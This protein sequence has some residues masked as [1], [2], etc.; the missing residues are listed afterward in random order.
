[1]NNTELAKLK[2][3]EK[4]RI[5]KTCRLSR[6]ARENMMDD[7][8]KKISK[9]KGKELINL[10]NK[11]RELEDIEEKELENESNRSIPNLEY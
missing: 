1:M 5:K 4:L 6:F 7:L 9:T 3:R 11:L 2:L 10:K 8:E